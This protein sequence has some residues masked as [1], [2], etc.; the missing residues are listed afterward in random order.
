MFNYYYD[1]YI[2]CCKFNKISTYGCVVNHI[3]YNSEQ[4][5]LVFYSNTFKLLIIKALCLMIWIVIQ[6]LF[7]PTSSCY[8]LAHN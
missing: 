6:L 3:S 5:K 8:R 7:T 2:L 1:V 4:I